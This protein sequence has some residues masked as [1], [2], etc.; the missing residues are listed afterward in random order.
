M[1]EKPILPLVLSMSL[2]MVISMAVS[3]LYNIIDSYFVA[4]ISE[5]AMT[6]LSLVFPI[7]NLINAVTIGYSI[8]IAAMISYHLGAG[9]QERAD[10]AASLGLLLSAVH[11]AALTIVCIAGMPVFLRL[12]TNDAAVI[13]MGLRYARIVLCFAPVIA[14]GMAWEKVFQAVGKML[15]TMAAMLC[16]C[17]TNIILD[18]LMIF[19]V[20]IFPELGIEGAALATGLGQTVS[21][22][23]YLAV[24]RVRPLPVRVRVKA[25]VPEREMALRIYSVGIPATLNLALPSL[26]ISS[27]NVIL[28][29]IAP[30][31]V[32]VLG[33]YYKLQTFLYLP[34]NGIVQGIRP[35]IGYNYGAGDDRRVRNIGLVSLALTAAI[36]AVGTVLCQTMPGALIGLFTESADTIAAGAGALRIISAGFLVSS[37]SVI[38]SGALEGLGKGRPS[39]MIS[40]ARYVVVILPAAFGLSRALGAAGVWHAFWVT[41][42]IAAAF[43]AAVYR[44][45]VRR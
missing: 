5:G 15:T 44:R 30:M 11:G 25:A 36:M 27:L 29:A 42:I 17:L 12:F 41:E 37:V 23:V 39:L 22:L 28:S 26:L 3:A 16:G 10:R 32:V 21:L 31:Y 2:P 20:G 9:E 34:A 38:A 18:P 24:Y 4:K 45:A 33:A 7:Q 6:A 35:L 1:K 40:L 8:G 13:D 43:S 14:L 19:G